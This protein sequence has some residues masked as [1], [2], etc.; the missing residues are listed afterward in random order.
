MYRRPCCSKLLVVGVLE[1]L[2]FGPLLSRPVVIGEVA[3][4]RRV[5][6]DLRGI[7]CVTAEKEC[8]DPCLSCLVGDRV[9]HTRPESGYVDNVRLCVPDR[10]QGV[11][12]VQVAGRI[13]ALS[14][15][16]STER[17]AKLSA[18]TSARPRE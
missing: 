4:V 14:D 9:Y 17:R 2:D 6:I 12:K 18:K 15:N 1:A 13:A 10:V 11:P 5:K 16:G 7:P 8:F 3:S